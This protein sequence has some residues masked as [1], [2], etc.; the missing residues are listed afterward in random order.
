MNKL[1]L[2]S[3]VTFSSLN[4]T[5]CVSQ[6]NNNSNKNS[7]LSTT[8]VITSSK[9]DVGNKYLV[10]GIDYIDHSTTYD[11]KKFVYDESM[12]YINELKDVPLPDPHVYYEDGL[13][14]ITGTS[15]RSNGKVVDCY[16]T[17]DFVYYDR[18]EIYNP[19]NYDGWEL[20][21]NPQIYAPE[22]YKF[23][24]KY[25]MYYS[26]NDTPEVPGGNS[27]RRNSVVVADKPAGPYKPIQNDKVDGL[28]NPLFKYEKSRGLDSTI[29]VDDDGRMYM[30]YV[31]TETTQHI[32]G[33]ELTSPYEADWSTKKDL[34]FPG[35]RTTE[36]TDI[37]LEW[38]VYRESS[39]SIAEAPYMIKSN[40]KYYMT[41]SVNGCWNKYYNVCYA[42]SDDPL[43]NYVKPYQE[44]GLWTN[45]LL[46][47]PG[48][49]DEESDV[50]N[51]WSE[52]ASGTGHHCFFNIGDQTMIGYHAHQSRNY[53]EHKEGYTARFFAF[54][55]VYF[56][57]D[58]VPFC[59]GPTNSLQ[60]LPEE[61]SSY[62]NIAENA[63]VNRSNVVNENY[64]NDNYIVDCYN[65]EA[66]NKE[67]IL[68]R[69]K[70]YIELEFDKEYTIG[71]IAIYNSAFYDE[72][73]IEV[74]S[75]DFTNDNVVYY[76]GFSTDAYMDEDKEFI[77]PGSAIT[78]EFP[79]T[80]KSSKVIICFNTANGAQI[81]EIKVLGK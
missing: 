21:Y 62:K 23:D 56:D 15:D 24:G 67:V 47:F 81:N 42:V 2:L 41:Y 52:F 30:Y 28:N 65:L 7:S 44:G 31:L 68:G 50:Y 43:G 70:S 4:L 73:V 8:N 5:G 49:N 51:Q 11:G 75:I 71:G 36:S 64:V 1:L 48:T 58:G 60:P 25:Y 17:E 54:D 29:F 79:K 3:L 22:I 80:F 61:I 66:K 9:S 72:A 27:V 57:K 78:V 35:T 38:E 46:G 37:E 12:W 74:D 39:L 40:G 6:G 69:G 59:N 45:L 13:Y 76:A 53:N 19:A 26:A 14:Y 16:I 55:Y 77:Y 63:K 10:E 20:D 34:V 18:K 33:V 32:V